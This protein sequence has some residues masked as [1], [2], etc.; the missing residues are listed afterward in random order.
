MVEEKNKPGTTVLASAF[1]A[2]CVIAGIFGVFAVLIIVLSMAAADS[3]AKTAPVAT[4]NVETLAEFNNV[5]VYVI[6]DKARGN[7]IYV[8]TKSAG[9]PAIA[10]VPKETK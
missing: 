6:D 7:F 3:P 4:K 2:V 8:T 5:G 1:K 9:S 10:V